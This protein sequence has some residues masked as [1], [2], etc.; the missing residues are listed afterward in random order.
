L[1]DDFSKEQITSRRQ[2]D[3]IVVNFVKKDS[4]GEKRGSDRQSE[5]H[6]ILDIDAYPRYNFLTVDGD[7]F[8]I[9]PTSG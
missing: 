8:V 6:I 7:T 5:F 1:P 9:V 2:G 4:F 3:T